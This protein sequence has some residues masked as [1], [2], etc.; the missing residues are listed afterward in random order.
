MSDKHANSL[1]QQDA[2]TYR[3]YPWG[4]L[5]VWAPDDPDR[6]IR[7]LTQDIRA[8]KRGGHISLLVGEAHPRIYNRPEF[9]KAICYAK[10]Q[11]AT[12]EA[13]TGAVMLEPDDSR[14]PNGLVSLYMDRK[15]DALYHRPARW[16]LGHFRVVEQEST[17]GYRY[18]YYREYPHAPVDGM[19][20]RCCENLFDF[21]ADTVNTKA[22]D[23]LRT[24]EF[25]KR[26]SV[27]HDAALGA[28]KV[29]FATQEDLRALV[30]ALEKKGLEF[31]FMTAEKIHKEAGK[32]VRT[33]PRKATP[34]AELV[35]MNHSEE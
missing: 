33:K 22:E 25:W 23:A 9:L 34:L 7:A 29:L 16:G 32:L 17:K 35:G 15:I 3:E 12:I 18:R 13:I 26:K 5:P 19:L 6:A 28:K 30:S 1:H 24:F 8:V 11:G 2:D 21:D 20:D 14:E 10:K 27:Q 4:Y 31:N